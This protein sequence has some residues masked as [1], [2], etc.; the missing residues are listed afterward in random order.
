MAARGR[1]RLFDREEALER[2]LNVFW[3]Q[4]YAATSMSDLTEA[5]GINSPSI[6][7]AFGSKEALFREAMEYYRVERGSLVTA[8][9]RD[10]PDAVTGIAR[11]FHLAISSYVREDDPKGCFIA[12]MGA[13]GAPEDVSLQA[14]I[15]ALRNERHIEIAHSLKADVAAGRLSKDTPVEALADLYAMLLHGASIAAKDGLSASRLRA[16][17]DA[18][19]AALLSWCILTCL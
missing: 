9:I 7:A 3:K 5:M 14:M 19:L 15:T 6:Y 2:A 4:G 8:A 13:G 17:C 1:P 10:A 18:A 12:G 16:A 11:M